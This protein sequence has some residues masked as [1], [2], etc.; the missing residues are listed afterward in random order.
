M[1]QTISPKGVTCFLKDGAE[2]EQGLGVCRHTA[3]SHTSR[4]N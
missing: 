3:S 4:H 2:D 1:I